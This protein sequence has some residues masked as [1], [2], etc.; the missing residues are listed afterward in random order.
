MTLSQRTFARSFIWMEKTWK[1]AWIVPLLTAC[2]F[3]Y[4]A[5]TAEPWLVYRN[6]PFPPTVQQVAPGEIVPLRVVRC[7]NSD[8]SQT[9]SIA[10]TLEGAQGISYVLDDTIVQIE[11]GC[12]DQIS[13]ANRIP[14]DVAPGRYRI[15]GL[16]AI[17]GTIRTI[18]VPWTSLQFDVVAK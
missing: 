1:W 11:K 5:W 16:T 6:L 2:F 15:I 10:R 4:K 8:T 17:Q 14:K 7:N 18:Y 13:L 3:A 12:T 9:Y